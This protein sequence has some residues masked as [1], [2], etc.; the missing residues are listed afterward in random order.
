M[1]SNSRY[2]NRTKPTA[3]PPR[4]DYK[5]D[6]SS[7]ES[8]A[9]K[10]AAP[11]SPEPSGEDADE[12]EFHYSGYKVIVPEPEPEPEPESLRGILTDAESQLPGGAKKNTKKKVKLNRNQFYCLSCRK[13]VYAKRGSIEKLSNRKIGECGVCNGKIGRIIK[14]YQKGLFDTRTQHSN[15]HYQEQTQLSLL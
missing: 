14:P 5:L 8:P 6:N 15:V 1:D 10:P 11:E 9:D 12:V 4:P 2:P 7:A 13:A 3:E